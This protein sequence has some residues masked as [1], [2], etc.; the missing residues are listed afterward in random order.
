MMRVLGG[1]VRNAMLL[2]LANWRDVKLEKA[3]WNFLIGNNARL[4]LFFVTNTG[5]IRRARLLPHCP[6][7][8]SPIWPIAAWL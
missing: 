2:I 1:G 4:G 6:L 5:S 3:I 8:R 7:V